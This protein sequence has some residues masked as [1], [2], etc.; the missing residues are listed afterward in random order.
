MQIKQAS[1]SIAFTTEVPFDT[2]ITEIAAYSGSTAKTFTPKTANAQSGYGSFCYY[3]A[4]G[5]GNTPDLSA[6]EKFGDGSFDETDGSV[7]LLIFTKFGTRNWVS[8]SQIAAAESPGGGGGLTQLTTPT[9]VTLGTATSTTQPITW[10]DTNTSPN[11]VSYKVQQSPA[12]A[13]TWTDSTMTSLSSTGATVTGLTAS[14]SYDYRVIA[15]GDGTAT[16]NSNPSSTVTGS[17]GAAGYDTR[18]Q[19]LFTAAGITD[20]THKGAINQFVLDINAFYT[21]FDFLH[22]LFTGDA[23]KTKFN[24]IDPTD[25]DASYRLTY[26]GSPAFAGTGVTLT[27]ASSHYINTHNILS[28]AAKAAD[29]DYHIGFFQRSAA[30]DAG[31]NFGLKDG[32]NSLYAIARSTD[33]TSY[34]KQIDG[35]EGSFADASTGRGF[36]LL[37]ARPTTAP[38]LATD[39]DG[40][41]K[42]GTART[43]SC[44][45]PS[46]YELL[47][48]ARNF[49]G[50]IGSHRN[51]ELTLICGGSGLSDSERTALATAVANLISTIAA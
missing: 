1:N 9:G 14:T 5:G 10:T 24:L 13:G 30:G 46:T 2:L 39:K 26:N 35:A 12:G 48:G 7:N 34:F 45:L 37:N 20:T 33:N 22:F 28:A 47:F 25:A 11:E 15:V 42:L 17:T 50:T 49:D 3:T 51:C 41:Q 18:A 40:T 16:S 38:L 4:N 43:F 29:T 27:A 8:I 21:K 6:F 31:W 44:V 36:Y 23:T 19:A 32:A